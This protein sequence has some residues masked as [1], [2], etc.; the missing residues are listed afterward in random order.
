MILGILD[1]VIYIFTAIVLFGGVVLIE[2]LIEGSPIW[3]PLALYLGY[4]RLWKQN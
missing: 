4:T 1:L 3:V 2:A